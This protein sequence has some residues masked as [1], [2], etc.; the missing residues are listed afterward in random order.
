VRRTREFTFVSRWPIFDAP[1]AYAIGDVVMPE[2]R[3]AYHVSA[4]LVF[5]LAV[6]RAPD[7]HHHKRAI[8]LRGHTSAMVLAS[9]G[10]RSSS[11]LDR[12]GVPDV[13]ERILVST[14]R[15]S[16]ASK[17]RPSRGQSPPRR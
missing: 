15:S 16:P 11:R 13:V 9:S 7:G 8:C 6:A 5:V 14:C 10:G 17:A 1:I 4:C 3:F 2:D 12:V